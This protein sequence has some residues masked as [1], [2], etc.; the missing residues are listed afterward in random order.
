M[1][2]LAPLLLLGATAWALGTAQVVAAPS[3]ASPAV[4]PA[5]LP[6]NTASPGSAGRTGEAGPAAPAEISQA[7]PSARLVGQG[8]FRYFGFKVYDARLW[9]SADGDP[10]RWMQ[11]P[12]ALELRYARSLD[13]LAIAER[14]LVEM[15][16]Q[17]AVAEADATRWL[18]AMRAAFPNVVDGD[19]LVGLSDGR[20]QVRFLH[21]GRP[22]ATLDDPEFARRFF[23]IWLLP[24]TSATSLREA[25]LGPA[26]KARP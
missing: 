1:K 13:G 17:G 8:P 11:Q 18:A 20:G 10:A 23:G 7:W 25:L 15:R 16:R 26:A 19:R 12:L 3:V 5:A 24:T 6:A 2:P 14:S 9:M 4:T 21:N 22:T